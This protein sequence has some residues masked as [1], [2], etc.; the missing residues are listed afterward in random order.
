MSNYGLIRKG[1]SKVELL[2]IPIP[3]VRDDYILVKTVAIALQPTDWTSLDAV[4][5]PGVLNGC[6][7]AGVVEQAG[8]KVTK[9]KKGDRVAGLSH[10]GQW[11]LDMPRPTKPN[12]G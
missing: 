9:F 6:D 11:F 8:S 1:T 10:G 3:Q 2:E 5:N 4:G 12:W 7:F